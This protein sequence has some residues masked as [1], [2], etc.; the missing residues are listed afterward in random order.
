LG[1]ITRNVEAARQ[2]EAIYESLRTGERDGQ[3]TRTG[4]AVEVCAR[5]HVHVT[6]MA[7]IFAALDGSAHITT[8]HQEAALAIW[9]YCEA[10][11]CY[12]FGQLSGDPI[13]EVIADALAA[14]GPLS[15]TDISRLFNRNVEASAIQAALD[16]LASA[17]RASMHKEP[18]SGGP[19]EIWTACAPAQEEDDEDEEARDE[20]A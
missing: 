15:R 17:W 11:A 9:D 19:R 7:L 16:S 14:R 18:T 1:A 10:C 5:A 3:S 8:A 12:L 20:T 13:V 2:W 6:R 4:M